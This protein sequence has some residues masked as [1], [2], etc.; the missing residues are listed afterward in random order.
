MRRRW[1]KCSNYKANCFLY[2]AFHNFHFYRICSYDPLYLGRRSNVMLSALFSLSKKAHYWKLY[3]VPLLSWNPFLVSQSF[4][5]SKD[6]NNEIAVTF[7]W[8]VSFFYNKQLIK[9]YSLFVWI[10]FIIHKRCRLKI[11]KC[12]KN[13]LKKWFNT[14]NMLSAQK[15]CV[16]L[17]SCN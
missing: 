16:A 7:F 12:A 2:F 13:L 6:W 10:I 9:W 11:E 3:N 1:R 17:L 8:R 5:P 14:L 4:S 15:T